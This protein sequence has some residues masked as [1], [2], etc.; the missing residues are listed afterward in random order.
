MRVRFR[1]ESLFILKG[2]IL[3][4]PLIHAKNASQVHY[5]DLLAIHAAQASTSLLPIQ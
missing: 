3:L 5:Q 4:H 1:I 2:I